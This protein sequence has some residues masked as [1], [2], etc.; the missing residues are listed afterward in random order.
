MAFFTILISFRR[1]LLVLFWSLLIAGVV[2]VSQFEKEYAEYN[3]YDVL[4]ID[5]VSNSNDSHYLRVTMLEVSQPV[6]NQN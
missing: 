1:A 4:E 2:K 3:P 6:C 5:R